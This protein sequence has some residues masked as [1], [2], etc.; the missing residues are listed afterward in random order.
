MAK[1][2]P[3]QGTGRGRPPKKVE[4][5]NVERTG[6]PRAVMNIHEA[7]DYLRFS[8]STVYKM[9]V[10]NEIPAAKLRGEW[11]FTKRSLDE[12]LESLIKKQ[13]RGK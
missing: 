11:R 1:G 7:A 9:A 4:V 13:G 5:E 3:K 12:W 6:E 8:E 2:K 10:N